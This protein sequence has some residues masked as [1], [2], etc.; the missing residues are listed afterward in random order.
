MPNLLSPLFDESGNFLWTLT[1]TN[2]NSSIVQ[3][4]NTLN[5]FLSS[6]F[7]NSGAKVSVSSILN[8]GILTKQVNNLN[9][10]SNYIFTTFFKV[11]SLSTIFKTLTFTFISYLNGVSGE[12]IVKTVSCPQIGDSLFKVISLDFTTVYDSVMVQISIPGNT[13]IEFYNLGVYEKSFGNKYHYDNHGILC[14]SID[15]QKVSRIKTDYEKLIKFD[16]NNFLK[17]QI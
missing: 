8:T 4:D 9:A 3:A 14:K 2:G 16:N 7:S 12:Q 6:I 11:N 1:S 13:N 15:G 10:N 5:D 17:A